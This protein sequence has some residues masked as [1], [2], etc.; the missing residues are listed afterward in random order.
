MWL[1]IARAVAGRTVGDL[2]V[3]VVNYKNSANGRSVVEPDNCGCVQRADVSRVLCVVEFWEF[4]REKFF[5]FTAVCRELPPL[6][7]SH[8]SIV[9][10]RRPGVFTDVLVEESDCSVAVW[11]PAQFVFSTVEL[12]HNT[13]AVILQ[14]QKQHQN[15]NPNTREHQPTGYFLGTL[16]LSPVLHSLKPSGGG[17]GALMDGVM[18]D[19]MFIDQNLSERSEFAKLGVASKSEFQKKK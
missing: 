17:V 16:K 15:K 7:P 13:P 5:A 1:E 10:S 11:D 4:E 6:Q 18:V 3:L 9:F 2:P 19:L 14:A 8:S 12:A